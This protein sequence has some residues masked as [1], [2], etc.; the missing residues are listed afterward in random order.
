MSMIS[1]DVA[2]RDTARQY[3][4][5]LLAS[6]FGVPAAAV[7]PGVQLSMRDHA[8]E[9]EFCNEGTRRRL[10]VAT[11]TATERDTFNH[12]L[13]GGE[14][15]GEGAVRSGPWRARLRDRRSPCSSVRSKPGSEAAT[16]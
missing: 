12:G 15:A 13:E 2:T 6:V 16:S 3:K 14:G 8:S 1:A 4:R 7:A 10:E 5:E 11:L 9:F